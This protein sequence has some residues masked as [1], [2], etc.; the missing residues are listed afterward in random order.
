MYIISNHFVYYS[1][2]DTD[3]QAIIK[4]WKAR[5]ANDNKLLAGWID[6]YFF[7]A[8]DFVLK[9]NDFSVETTLVGAVLSGLSHLKGVTVK[10]EF[11]C[12]LIRGMGSNLNE[13]S[14]VALAKEVLSVYLFCF[15]LCL[16]IN[17]QS[18]KVAQDFI[19]WIL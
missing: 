14:K 5:E 18:V 16:Y 11:A 4:S 17:N 8:L 15:C 9:R 1:N 19:F 13:D 10:A 7:K 12:A 2:E 3:T 6:D